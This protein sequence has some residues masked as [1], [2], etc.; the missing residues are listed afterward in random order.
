MRVALPGEPVTDGAGN[1]PRS[2]EEWLETVAAS[3]GVSEDEVID[4]MM[5]SYWIL[6]ELTGLVEESSEQN[7]AGEG[8]IDTDSEPIR[9]KDATEAE[10]RDIAEAGFEQL[11]QVAKVL[12]QFSADQDDRDTATAHGSI[13]RL[14]SE[15]TRLHDDIERLTT[16]IDGLI[17]GNRLGAQNPVDHQQP[18]VKEPAVTKDEFAEFAEHVE[19]LDDQLSSFE[20]RYSDDQQRVNENFSDVED[21]L[22][23]LIGQL[24]ALDERLED[25]ATQVSTEESD[26]ATRERLAEIKQLANKRGIRDARC[27]RCDEPVDLVLLER[28]EC[29]HCSH[30]F[31]DLK[32]QSIWF[33]LSE[34]HTLTLASPESLRRTGD[35][36][37][38]SHPETRDRGTT[39]S[40]ES[41]DSDTESETDIPATEDSPLVS[42]ALL[43][44]LDGLSLRTDPADE[45]DDASTGLRDTVNS[46]EE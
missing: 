15:V 7:G 31:E 12:D 3:E 36:I 35:S 21:I 41:I 25:V 34:S 33:G 46:D 19:K 42:D 39:T 1:S 30:P 5:S 37:E 40:D 13:E 17:D 8:A 4:R 22:Q 6:H 11:L 45:E 23:Y 27:E 10:D 16:R 38:T 28:A 29:P 26:T 32:S 43:D 9:G 44:E 24:D 14:D 2:F 20:S 18:V